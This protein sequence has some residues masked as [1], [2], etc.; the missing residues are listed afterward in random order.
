MDTKIALSAKELELVCNTEWILTKHAIIQ[1]VYELFGNVLPLMQNILEESK[2]VLPPEIFATAPKISKG[3]NYKLLPYVIMDYPRHFTKDDTVAIRT[4]FWWGHFFSISLQLAGRHKT[5]AE[6]KMVENFEWLQQNG[7][8]VCVSDN[9]WEHQ[10]DDS[11]F[12]LLHSIGK[13]QFELLLAQKPFIKIANNIPLAQW[14]T[15]PV[16]IVKSFA[17]LAG[18]LKNN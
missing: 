5:N 14:Q 13:K 10:F 7:Y 17:E 16:F 15:V 9:P 12:I 4:F 3:E 18:L 8:A 11:N 2:A 1:K 6:S